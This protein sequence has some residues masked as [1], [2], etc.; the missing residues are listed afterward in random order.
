M[1]VRKSDLIFSLLFVP[2]SFKVIPLGLAGAKVFH[3]TSLLFAP[4]IRRAAFLNKFFLLFFASTVATVFIQFLYS[5]QFSGYY[6]ARHIFW[7]YC[8]LIGFSI[9]KRFPEKDLISAFTVSVYLVVFLVFL[10]NLLYLDV[11]VSMFFSGGAHPRS[12]W[13][14]FNPGYNVNSEVT[15]VAIFSLLGWGLSENKKYVLL[16]L[17]FALMNALVSKVNGAILLVLLYFVIATFVRFRSEVKIVGFVVGAIGIAVIL[18]GLSYEFYE[19]LGSGRLELWFVAAEEIKKFSFLEVFLGRGIGSLASFGYFEDLSLL[20][21]HNIFIDIFYEMGAVG[22]LIYVLCILVPALKVSLQ[23][24]T[25]GNT[26]NRSLGVV[27]L[28]VLF[29]GLFTPRPL[30]P[31][32]AFIVGAFLG[33]SSVMR[34][35]GERHRILS[36]NHAR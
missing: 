18:L 32:F 16:I 29:N 12:P 17:V 3:L 10:K 25:A 19:E 30:D 36:I 35:E 22:L 26:L 5:G 2:L 14:F 24:P 15:W 9:A 31:M 28:L 1:R 33:T 13:N 34:R 7:L 27:V 21:F 8:F 23:R 11:I 4:S 20:D 6:L